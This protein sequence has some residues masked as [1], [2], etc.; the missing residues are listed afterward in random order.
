[1]SLAEYCVFL[2]TYLDW[3]DSESIQF[4]VLW[5]CSSMWYKV[6]VPPCC[7]SAKRIQFLLLYSPSSSFSLLQF[8]FEPK[9]CTPY[10]VQMLPTQHVPVSVMLTLPVWIPV[11]GLFLWQRYSATYSPGIVIAGGY[12]FPCGWK[13]FLKWCLVL[14]TTNKMIIKEKTRVPVWTRL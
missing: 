3:H 2:S 4:Y 14:K 10:Y 12:L 8:T 11:C 7:Q 13:H 1:M 6:K 9:D 5:S